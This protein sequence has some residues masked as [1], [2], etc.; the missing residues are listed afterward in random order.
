MERGTLKEGEVEENSRLH[1]QKTPLI[2]LH[3]ITN[4]QNLKSKPVTG[5]AAGLPRLRIPLR[6]EIHQLE[7]RP[8]QKTG[9]VTRQ[10]E[11]HDLRQHS[12]DLPAPADLRPFHRPQLSEVS[13][14]KRE[15]LLSGGWQS[16]SEGV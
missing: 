3:I 15:V 7:P 6:L 4:L 8:I 13:H 2:T 12:H 5:Q 11:M 10:H 9:R 16:V 14:H 1:H